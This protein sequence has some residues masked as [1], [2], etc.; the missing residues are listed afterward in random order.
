MLSGEI[1]FKII[2]LSSSSSRLDFND[3]YSRTG[4]SPRCMTVENKECKS[5]QHI[6]ETK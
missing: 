1:T 4:K 3:F 2:I 5:I 6:N